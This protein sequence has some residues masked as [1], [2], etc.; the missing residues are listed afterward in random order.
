[1]YSKVPRVE[2]RKLG[3]KVIT[4]KWVDTN[5]GSEVE[6]NYRSRLVGREL[7]LSDRPDLFAATPIGKPHVYR[8]PVCLVSA[9]ATAPPDPFYRCQS[10]LLLR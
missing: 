1:M 5:T 8:Q 3:A 9:P 6:P 4:A 10:C 7:N 2:A